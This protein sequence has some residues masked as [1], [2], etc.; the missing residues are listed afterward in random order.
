MKEFVVRLEDGRYL[1]KVKIGSHYIDYELTTDPAAADRF[2]GFDSKLLV[3]RLHQRSL[4]AS[5][6]GAPAQ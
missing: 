4:K 5:R 2:T 3:E 6:E 1:Y